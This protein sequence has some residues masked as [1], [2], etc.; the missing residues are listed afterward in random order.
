[1]RSFVRAGQTGFSE[2]SAQFT[3]CCAVHPHEGKPQIADGVTITKVLA[4]NRLRGRKGRWDTTMFR[5]ITGL[6]M[7]LPQPL[8]FNS[9]STRAPSCWGHPASAPC[10]V[11][12]EEGLHH[13]QMMTWLP[14]P[15]PFDAPTAPCASNRSCERC[16]YYVFRRGQPTA[17]AFPFDAAAQPS[18]THCFMIRSRGHPLAEDTTCQHKA[19]H[20]DYPWGCHI[21][22]G[23]FGLVD[24]PIFSLD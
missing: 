22:T 13:H 11:A 24:G 2:R 16:C 3:L 12:S 8:D 21:R 17:S 20:E 4:P 5:A 1:M 14:C 10:A 6:M 9:S 18:K 15:D 19:M 23:R 7:G